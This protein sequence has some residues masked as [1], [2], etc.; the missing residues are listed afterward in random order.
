[1]TDLEKLQTVYGNL[2]TILVDT[3]T[4]PKPDYSIDGQQVSW[5]PYVNYIFG[6]LEKVEAQINAA[7]PY[8]LRSQ[9]L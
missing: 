3:T 4:N 9:I 1:M 8:E 2:L 7:D 6:W 5:A